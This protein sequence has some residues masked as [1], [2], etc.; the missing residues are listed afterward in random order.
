[1]SQTKKTIIELQKYLSKEDS[2]VLEKQIHAHVYEYCEINKI[3]KCLIDQVYTNKVNDILYN[4][5]SEYLLENIKDKKIKL[6]DI[7]LMQPFELDPVKWQQLL[8][9]KSVKEE[10]SNNVIESEV[11]TCH[12]CK[13]KKFFIYSLQTRSSDEPL[14]YFIICTA[15]R[16]TFKQ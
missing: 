2:E 16:F 4:L 12:K 3:N 13:S 15:C 8:K 7:P 6:E 11:F 10:K 1:M 14:T 5:K 9:I